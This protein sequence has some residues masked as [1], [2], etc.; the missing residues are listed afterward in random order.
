MPPKKS[1]VM[2]KRL[3]PLTYHLE[4]CIHTILFVRRIYPT[5]LFAK[6]KI[7]DAPVYQ[8][9]HPDLNKYISGAVKSVGDELIRVGTEKILQSNA[10]FLTSLVSSQFLRMQTGKSGK[11][12]LAIGM[13]DSYLGLI[14]AQWDPTFAV[15][16]EMKEGNIPSEPLTKKPKVKE[17]PPREWI[18]AIVQ[19]TT[20][21]TTAEA[22]NH[23]IRAVDTGVISLSLIV[24]ESEEKLLRV[25]TQE[26]SM[27]I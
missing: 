23:I 18:P 22:E 5:E 2:L 26:D 20:D 15:V 24:Q 1:P 16:M 17:K 9:R 25:A 14:P 13:L 27:K 21:G 8:S 19:N 7:Y 3:K 11:S 10:S 6:R 12:N 4:V